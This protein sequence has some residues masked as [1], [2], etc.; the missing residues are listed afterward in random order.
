MPRLRPPIEPTVTL[1]DAVAQWAR[2]LRASD[3]SP[4]TVRSYLYATG[5]LIRRVGPDRGVGSIRRDD[6]EALLATLKDEGL[7]AASRVAVYMPLVAFFKWAVAHPD[8]PVDRSPMDGVEKP[9]T[10]VQPVEFVGDDE[11]A[12]ILRTTVE[13]SKHAF[14]ARRDRAALLVLA[15]TGARLSEIANLR[16]QDVDLTTETITVMGKGGKLRVLPLLPDVVA[17]LRLYLERERPRSP[18]GALPNLWL[19][20]KGA[21]TASG[22]A[23]MLA[24]RSRAAGIE[25]RVHPHELRHRAIAS[26][27]KAGM[28][29]PYVMALS[30]HTT[31]S[32]LNRYGAYTRAQ[33]AM[34][35]LRGLAA[36]GAV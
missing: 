26:W 16:V 25:R 1:G 20:S 27:L 6:I 8:M 9:R 19:A 31:P 13:R 14:R 33:D 17:A 24:E 28:S 22:I 34:D 35:A 4:A 12:A 5:H 10:R 18:Y 15:T 23:Q 32:M 36:A 30:G 3:R 7:S 11:W 29:G 2:S 21:W